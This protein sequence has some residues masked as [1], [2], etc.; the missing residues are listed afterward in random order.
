[1]TTRLQH[2]ALALLFGASSFALTACGNKDEFAPQNPANGPGALVELSE[3][4]N[5]TFGGGASPDLQPRSVE[6]GG[7]W[8]NCD[9]E[10]EAY[11]ATLPFEN[12][13][14]QAMCPHLWG[15]GLDTRPV[16]DEQACRRIFADLTGQFPTYSQIESRCLGRP[17]GAIVEELIESESFV[18]QNQ[19]L[20][21][22][23]LRYNNVAVNLE[24]I[25]DADLLVGKLYRGLLR[26]DRFI[27]VVS[28][29]PVLMR[30]FDNAGD[31]AEAL[32]NIFVGRP[33]FENERA[34]MSK[35][36]NLW[37][38]GYFD[39]PELGM[40]LPDAFVEHKCLTEDG[41]EIDENTAGACTSV[42]WGF[43]RVI[44]LP[45]F[46]ATEAEQGQTVTWSENLTAEEWELL[47]TPGKIV[48]T[49]PVVWEHAV[50]DVLKQYLGY[51]IA[52]Q[53]PRVVEQLVEYVLQ[54]QGDLRAA[55]YAV[56]TS[57]LYLQST[58][59]EGAGCANQ[60]DYPR[61]TYGPFRQAEAELWIDSIGASASEILGA[62]DHRLSVPQQ[63]LEE[64]PIGYEVVEASRWD[65][66]NSGDEPRVDTEYSSFAQTLGGCPDNEV[67]GRFK[68][69]SI[70]ST[71]T[72]EA[73]VGELCGPA[74]TGGGVAVDIL[75]PSSVDAGD[76]LTESVAEQILDFQVKRFFSRRP[77][78]EEL[79][80]A[81]E[82]SQTC[83][84]APCDAEDFARVSCYALLSSSEMLFY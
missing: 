14:D 27:E 52:Q 80:M 78:D 13:V 31:R 9:A 47:Q 50:E 16:D 65:L 29:H 30:R 55:H 37:F 84:P 56:L 2:T 48:A 32:F 54:H 24:R 81:R 4:L 42:L 69:V 36:Y 8:A 77:L 72:Q 70:L 11:C 17:V 62:C 61:W 5:T 66:D 23:K 43:N 71:A 39:H 3:P 58:Q 33:P 34:D 63:L 10:C 53:T 46:R 25:Y 12:P 67:A 18:F 6:E 1:M 28:A 19:R 51:D 74:N 79:T 82:T 64:S 22:D 20:W 76:S 38:N 60:Q 41:T 75:L 59:C 26:Y 57:Q 21:A 83:T 73:F 68:A 35:L 45:D 44:L 7:D 15:V 40:R 49:W